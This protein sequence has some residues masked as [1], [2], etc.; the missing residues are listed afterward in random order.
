MFFMWCHIK[1]APF[2]IDSN[3]DAVIKTLVTVKFFHL[4]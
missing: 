2:Q 3:A 4:Y 1:D